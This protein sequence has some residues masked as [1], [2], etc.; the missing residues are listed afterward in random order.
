M[1]RFCDKR[2]L[3]VDNEIIT[4]EFLGKYF[5]EHPSDVIKLTNDD[6]VIGFVERLCVN[7]N[8]YTITRQ[9]AE[10]NDFFWNK[11]NDF[12]REHPR[13]LLPVRIPNGGVT[14]CY[15]DPEYNYFGG[16]FRTGI[17]NLYI[18]ESVREYLNLFVSGINAV[19]IF[20]FNEYAFH[21]YRILHR[22]GI[23]TYVWGKM[24]GF[25]G[26]I[27]DREDFQDF[28]LL[29]VYS[30]GTE[31]VR[32]ENLLLEPSRYTSP[33]ANLIIINKL[34]WAVYDKC[35]MDRIKELSE[36]GIKCI[37][38]MIPWDAD[39][40]YFTEDEKLS[41]RLNAGLNDCI[42]KKGDVSDEYSEVI[43]RIHGR[44]TYEYF[45]EL[46]RNYNI[47]SENPAREKCFP[48]KIYLIGPCIVN[49]DNSMPGRELAD[50][51][52]EYVGVK[53]RVIRVF[54]RNLD[55]H[56]W[57]NNVE[58]L[59]ISSDDILVFIDR[60]LTVDVPLPDNTVNLKD[61]YNAPGR[62]T[63]FEKR[64][65]IHTNSYAND[66][67]AKKIADKVD[68]LHGRSSSRAP[69][70]LQKGEILGSEDIKKIGAY[71]NTLPHIGNSDNVG[72][73]VMNC[74]PFTY[75]HLFLISEAL[76]TVDYLYL[77]VVTENKSAISFAD[78]FNMVK[79]GVSALDRVIA[80]PSGEFILSW[81]TF[82]SYFEKEN[83]QHEKVDAYLDL[84][85]FA[86]YIAS[87]LNIK[88]RFVGEEPNDK[89]TLQYNNQM[90]EI[91][92][93]YG[94]ELIEIP[95]AMTDSGEIISASTVRKLL[96]NRDFKTLSRYVPD[97]TL[98]YLLKIKGLKEL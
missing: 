23:K 43:K 48:Q 41:Y 67:I 53:Y 28:E 83:I 78:R 70:V 77:F 24:W 62:S 97:S 34:A 11:A 25:F 31:L 93:K 13:L 66:L 52:Q 61:M 58:N 95:R 2:V 94:V 37:N 5:A 74:N 12:F 35:K 68:E 81:S 86:R 26:I 54:C 87:Q 79:L 49:G 51:L 76:K 59:P 1:I 15:D 10:I 9:I 40:T 18:V 84:H 16:D 56:D 92:P 36:K 6:E 89:V 3:D 88:Y 7:D 65:T 29:Y 71:C 73:V 55:L 63:L 98:N 45:M 46:G 44:E 90:K 69:Y 30:E 60:G 75:G 4:Q 82:S 47:H 20:G 17:N 64:V 50:R 42:M 8:T 21:L 80:V 91:L 85:I 38:V 57:Q 27:N 22:S 32:K 96:H 19:V 72:A 33:V 14:F 39:V